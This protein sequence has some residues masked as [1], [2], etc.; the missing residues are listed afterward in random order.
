MEKDL[1]EILKRSHLCRGLTDEQVNRLSESGLIKRI[2]YKRNE[3]L[4]WTDKTPEKLVMLLSGNTAMGR[5]TFDG[6][7]S[8]SKNNTTP[9]IMLNEI[10]LF[11]QKK[12]LWDYAVALE[13]SEVLEISSK[14]FLE[15]NAGYSDVQVAVLQNMMSGF[16]DK[17]SSLGE[18]V[19]ILSLASVRDRIAYY[20]FHRQDK[21]RLIT[22][23][24]TREEIAD[25]LGIARP[26]LSRELGRMQDE[27]LIR[28][29][30]HDVTV[31]DE[32]LFNNI[33][34]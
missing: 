32:A 11:S 8:L 27:G 15:P 34:E 6:K 12:L 26:S 2:R 28:I 14:I 1:F 17:I 23:T 3:I 33:F 5:D 9:G 24:E 20:L 16:V 19:A 30:G 10:R 31:L 21:Q 18:K 29:D 7:R 13:D 22:V 4:F 25:Y